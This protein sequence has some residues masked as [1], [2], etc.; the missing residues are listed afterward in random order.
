MRAITE[1]TTK[2]WSGSESDNVVSSLSSS[3]RTIIPTNPPNYSQNSFFENINNN[4]KCL[5]LQKKN[6][7]GNNWV[8]L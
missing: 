3:V 6:N 5:I 8:G 7:F 2:I 4:I 1:A